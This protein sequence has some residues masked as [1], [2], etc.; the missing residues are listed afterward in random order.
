MAWS[1]TVALDLCLA[2]S[3][4]D[5]KTPADYRIAPRRANTH[6]NPHYF[7]AREDSGNE[8]RARHRRRLRPAFGIG[9]ECAEVIVF[10][11]RG[12]REQLRRRGMM[13]METAPIVSVVP[14]PTRTHDAN[15]QH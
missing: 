9:L 10:G 7:A 13:P 6:R 1:A 15:Y 3:R 4:I 2:F 12:Q 14:L 11:Y 8:S 5:T